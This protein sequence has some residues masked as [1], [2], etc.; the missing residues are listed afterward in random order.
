MI[1]GIANLVL[2]YFLH[3]SETPQDLSNLRQHLVSQTELADQRQA[4]GLELDKMAELP[5]REEVVS[6]IRWLAQHSLNEYRLTSPPQDNAYYYF[7]RLLQLD[8]G[9]TEA[10]RGIKTIA[11]RYAVLADQA[12]AANDNTKARGYISLG[13]QIDPDNPTLRSLQ[14]LAL[15]ERNSFFAKLTKWF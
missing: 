3:S 4:A 2:A 9:D 6:A 8:P 12:I 11:E 10:A 14:G 5:N 15:P 13:L 1:V 7:S